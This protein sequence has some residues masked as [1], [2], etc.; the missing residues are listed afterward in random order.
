MYV[1]DEAEPSSVGKLFLA[2]GN[3]KKLTDDEV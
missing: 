2:Y 1:N 3:S